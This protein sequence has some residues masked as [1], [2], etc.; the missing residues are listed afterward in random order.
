MSIFKKK[1]NRVRVLFIDQKNDFASQM[2]EY[3]TT[4][5]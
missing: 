4:K 1:E 3:F 2:A 5:F